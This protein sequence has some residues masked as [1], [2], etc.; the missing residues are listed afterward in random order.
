MIFD[1]HIDHAGDREGEHFRI[2]GKHRQR[3]AVIG[4]RAG[5][6]P[7]SDEQITHALGDRHERE[8]RFVRILISPDGADVVRA[9]GIGELLEHEAL[10]ALDHDVGAAVR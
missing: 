2:I 7:H 5:G 1:V 6:G 4:Q 10:P 9:I 8:R 3:I